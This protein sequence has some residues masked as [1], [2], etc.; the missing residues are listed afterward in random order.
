MIEHY[1][2]LSV[3]PDS[4]Y[5]MIHT[6]P[7]AS[8]IPINKRLS[9]NGQISILNNIHDPYCICCF[10]LLDSIPFDYNDLFSDNTNNTIAC[11]YSIWSLKKGSGRVMIRELTDYIKY[12]LNIHTIVTLSPNTDTARNFHLN[13][14]ATVY[15]ENLNYDT[16]NY[17]YC[18]K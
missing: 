3:I 6:D 8:Q 9:R 17:M 18:D 16:V 15:R 10:V 11:L 13:N 4:L 12:D 5:D 1:N 7:V 2:S 14:G